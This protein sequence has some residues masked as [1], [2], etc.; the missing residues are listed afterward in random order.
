VNPG[1]YRA[2]NEKI[3]DGLRGMFEKYTGKKVRFVLLESLVRRATANM[4]LGALQVLKLN[5]SILTAQIPDEARA[6]RCYDMDWGL[7]GHM[8]T[9]KI[10]VCLILHLFSAS[11]PSNHRRD[12]ASQYSIKFAAQLIV[13]HPLSYTATFATSLAC[14]TSNRL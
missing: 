7:E 14:I 2:Q 13:A 5:G 10:P 3:T 1:Q 11:R 9:I 8:V 4:V 12:T 6:L